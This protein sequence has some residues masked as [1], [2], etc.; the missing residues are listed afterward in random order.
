M[1]RYT[2]ELMKLVHIFLQHY[3]KPDD[4]VRIVGESYEAQAFVVDALTL[5][6]EI[7]I[8]LDVAT[9]LPFD[10]DRKVRDIMDVIGIVGPTPTLID[11]L[12]RLIDIP[13]R[14]QVLAELGLAPG[15]EMIE[16]EEEDVV[17][18]DFPQLAA[19]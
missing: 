9:A 7:D 3:L 16:E 18:A 17:N 10:K 2:I 13:K 5:D 19:V 15:Q 6:A 4:V 14:Q 12:L 1:D 8:D 11:Q